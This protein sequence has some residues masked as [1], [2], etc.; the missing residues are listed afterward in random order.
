M[1]IQLDLYLNEMSFIHCMTRD[2][3]AIIQMDGK[4]YFTVDYVTQSSSSATE[5]KITT[6]EKPH[7]DIDI[8]DYVNEFQN[9]TAESTA[10]TVE[11]EEQEVTTIVNGKWN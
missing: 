9:N 6:S 3:I 7:D 10:D 2:S 4:L 5:R 11:E 1:Q 8:D